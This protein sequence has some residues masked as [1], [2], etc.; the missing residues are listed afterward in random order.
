MARQPLPP[1]VKEMATT[2]MVTR[3]IIMQPL[4]GSTRVPGIRI[5][6][7]PRAPPPGGRTRR[8]D[9]TSEL[10]DSGPAFALNYPDVWRL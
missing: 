7:V 9:L 1:V 10:Y 4:E 2:L 3:R 6:S 8:T 5:V